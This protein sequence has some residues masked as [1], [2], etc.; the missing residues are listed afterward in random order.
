[1][2]NTFLSDNVQNL[3]GTRMVP[4]PKQPWGKVISEQFIQSRLIVVGGS[5]VP[6]ALCLLLFG[7][8]ILFWVLLIFPAI[9][10]NS[11]FSRSRYAAKR[12]IK[13]Y[14][15][16]RDNALLS[17][18]EIQALN[19]C[20]RFTYRDKGWYNTYENYPF[21]DRK[22]GYD[23][24]AFSETRP[25]QHQNF[26]YSEHLMHA[27]KR[28]WGISSK[29]A[30]LSMIHDLRDGRVHRTAVVTLFNQEGFDIVYD[31]LAQLSGAPHN[32]FHPVFFPEEEIADS[33]GILGQ[34]M[35]AAL[36]QFGLDEATFFKAIADKCAELDDPETLKPHGDARDQMFQIVRHIGRLAVRND[37]RN[38][39]LFDMDTIDRVLYPQGELDLLSLGWGFDLSRGMFLLRRAYAAGFLTREELQHELPAYRKIASAAFPDWK[40]Y[41]C[42]E[43]I[44]FLSWKVQKEDTSDAYAAASKAAE[45]CHGAL[46]Q[47]FPIDNQVSWPKA[48]DAAQEELKRLFDGGEVNPFFMPQT[49]GAKAMLPSL[50]E[51]HQP[52][53]AMLH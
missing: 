25:Y 53:G 38:M 14:H 30:A 13:R 42:S 39:F 7:A 16:G 34:S 49:L 47:Q 4:P 51:I 45:E 27:L 48:D 28:D 17:E 35:A 40:A 15:K 21:W 29:Q 9:M 18:D 50:E 36:D 6:A 2:T 10:V 1:M 11:S 19:L 46:R 20:A 31:L 44:G 43:A 23:D 26:D 32:S 8:G 3:A 12:E 41:F 5:A 33:E 24:P 37:V 52:D 22:A